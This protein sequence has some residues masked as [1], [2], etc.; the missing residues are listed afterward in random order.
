[1]LSREP[2]AR[3][4]LASV[5]DEAFNDAAVIGESPMHVPDVG[6]GPFQFDAFRTE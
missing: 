4:G 5:G 6:D 3:R 2:H 1:M